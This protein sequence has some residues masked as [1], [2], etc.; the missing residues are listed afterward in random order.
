MAVRKGPL[1]PGHS[2]KAASVG[3]VSRHNTTADALKVLIHYLETPL[4]T[5]IPA[6]GN[7]R[8]TSKKRYVLAA[9]T[10]A[11]SISFHLI[12]CPIRGAGGGRRS[13]NAEDSAF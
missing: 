2:S 4:G 8:K 13:L 11:E 5:H 6:D 7:Q 9:A 12:F 1:W 10:P 3:I